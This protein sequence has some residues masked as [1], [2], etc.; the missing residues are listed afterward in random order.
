MRALDGWISAPL[1]PTS[2]AI[3]RKHRVVSLANGISCTAKP[4]EIRSL[5]PSGVDLTGF[6]LLEWSD[7]IG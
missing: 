7:L 3:G 2:I 6:R 4:S 1:G 5:I